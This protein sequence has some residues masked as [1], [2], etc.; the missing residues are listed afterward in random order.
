MKVN[1][2]ILSATEA[3]G[4]GWNLQPTFQRKTQPSKALFSALTASAKLGVLVI[5]V[6]IRNNEVGDGRKRM[7]VLQQW[8]ANEKNPPKD[9]FSSDWQTLLNGTI[10]VASDYDLRLPQFLGEF[11]NHN[12][13]NERMSTGELLN[14]QFHNFPEEVLSLISGNAVIHKGKRLQELS[15]LGYLLTDSAFNARSADVL[16]KMAEKRDSI[17][18][19]Q[20][21]RHINTLV[22]LNG[23]SKQIGFAISEDRGVRKPTSKS[24]QATL[25]RLIQ[26]YETDTIVDFERLREAWIQYVNSTKGEAHR[27]PTGKGYEALAEYLRL[28]KAKKPA[29]STK[30]SA[31]KQAKKA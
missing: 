9:T 14:A 16:S 7:L 31:G 1:V 2:S 5:P 8:E 29:G 4:K 18:A 28:P 20:I 21:D 23:L 22:R 12:Q 25:L 19:E 17:T 10:V 6:M 27:E 30:H 24:D 11:Q 15:F 26:N 3:L 13:I